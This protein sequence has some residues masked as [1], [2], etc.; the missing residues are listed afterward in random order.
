MK[1]DK[2]RLKYIVIAALMVTITLL[3]IFYFNSA[4]KAALDHFVKGEYDIALEDFNRVKFYRNSKKYISFVE[5]LQENN[6]RDEEL[7]NKI[8]EEGTEGQTYKTLITYIEGIVA[9]NNEKLDEAK[10]KF[11]SLGDFIQSKE[12]LEFI[13]AVSCFN[14][15]EF[16]KCRQI[17]E[18]ISFDETSATEKLRNSYLGYMKAEEELAA[19]HYYS[20]FIEY[21]RIKGFRDSE[22]KQKQCIQPSGD[23]LFYM[24]KEKLSH[25]ITLVFVG[26]NATDKIVKI[27]DEQGNKVAE[28]YLS[29]D[30]SREL[31]IAAGSYTITYG[32]GEYYFGEEDWFGIETGK[33]YL[34]RV[35]DDNCHFYGSNYKYTIKLDATKDGSIKLVNITFE[36]F[37]NEGTDSEN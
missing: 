37:K 30:S 21:E 10:E 18:E 13:D 20:S 34:V 17:L 11:T 25:E 31:D 24:N 15:S 23:K 4:Y 32:S 14:N 27:A 6:I 33:Y 5:V 1:K 35:K 28:F 16:D 2:T 22:E 36:E 3:L 12:Y 29:K 19:K 26:S 9:F 7:L 8:A